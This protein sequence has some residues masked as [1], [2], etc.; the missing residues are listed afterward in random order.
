MSSNEFERLDIGDNEWAPQNDFVDYIYNVVE[1]LWKLLPEDTRT[2]FRND[3]VDL[4]CVLNQNIDTTKAK[5]REWVITRQDLESEFRL[6]LNRYTLE[7][8]QILQWLIAENA[9]M[10]MQ[11]PKNLLE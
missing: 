11:L 2:C 10:K 6:H 8:E 5:Y 9:I 4:F 3:F 1:D 7:Y